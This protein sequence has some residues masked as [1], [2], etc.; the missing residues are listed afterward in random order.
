MIPKALLI[1]LL[2]ILAICAILCMIITFSPKHGVRRYDC[3]LAEISPDYP[4]DVKQ[5]CRKLNAKD[6]I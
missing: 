4:P 2:Q 5:E 3:S 6:Y 1:L